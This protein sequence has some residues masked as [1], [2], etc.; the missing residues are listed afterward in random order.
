MRMG[1]SIGDTT[2]VSSLRDQIQRYKTRALPVPPVKPNLY[3]DHKKS[4]GV[5]PAHES[6]ALKCV[7]QIVADFERLPAGESVPAQYIKEISSR[8]PLTLSA[9]VAG[10]T[11]PLVKTRTLTETSHSLATFLRASRD[12]LAHVLPGM[13][14]G[15]G[16]QPPTCSMRTTGSGGVWSSWGG[17]TATSRSTGS[18]GSSSSSRTTS[19]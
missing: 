10:E 9:K 4:K 13:L 12:C 8:L 5:N 2:D 15:Y 11:R 3:I 14:T 6:L 1:L 18:C 16:V 17:H 19:R 7:R